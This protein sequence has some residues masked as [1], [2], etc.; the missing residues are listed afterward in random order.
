MTFPR[1]IWLDVLTFAVLFFL[2]G[3]GLD[4]LSGREFDFG[5]R[6]AM[7][8]IAVPIYFVIKLWLIKRK[9]KAPDA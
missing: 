2:M 3:L 5:R 1:K 6:G 4:W 7:T 8:A 9:A